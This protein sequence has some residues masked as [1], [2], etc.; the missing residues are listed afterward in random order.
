MHTACE[1]SRCLTIYYA[2]YENGEMKVYAIHC[3]YAGVRIYKQCIENKKERDRKKEIIKNLY[4]E[5]FAF[6]KRRCA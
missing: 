2:L 5:I 4:G 1:K 6:G 3:M